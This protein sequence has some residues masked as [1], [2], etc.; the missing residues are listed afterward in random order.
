MNLIVALLTVARAGS[1]RCEIALN[2]QALFAH[3][4]APTAEEIEA[5]CALSTGVEEGELGHILDCYARKK[6]YT[7][8]ACADLREGD[9]LVAAHPDCP[10]WVRSASLQT[11]RV[12]ALPPG[13]QCSAMVAHDLPHAAEGLVALQCMAEPNLMDTP[14]C[15]PIRDHQLE[16][17]GQECVANL[18][19]IR[20]AE[21]AHRWMPIERAPR[22]VPDPQAVAWTSNDGFTTIGWGP[23]REVYGVYWVELTPD[24][25]DALCEVDLDGDGTPARYL[26]TQSE[27]A[28]AI[29]G[30]EVR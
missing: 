2:N 7:G 19:A 12:P 17:A 13:M 4:A 23:A 15:A 5:F 25:F 11:G 10:N 27:R 26:A 16:L 9:L 24:G 8:E 21:L 29:T 14:T 18:N 3:L 28:H 20:V 22:S 30:T 1:P 6:A